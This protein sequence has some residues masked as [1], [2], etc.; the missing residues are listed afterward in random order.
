MVLAA[1]QVEGEPAHLEALAN[2]VR[3]HSPP[4]VLDPHRHLSPTWRQ[5]LAVSLVPDLVERPRRV[6]SYEPA[7]ELLVDRPVARLDHRSASNHQ[8]S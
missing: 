8:G 6:Q 1:V 5:H 2:D 7:L 4:Y 3:R